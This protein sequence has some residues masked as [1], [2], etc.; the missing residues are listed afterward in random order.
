MCRRAVQV[1]ADANY[2]MIM[3]RWVTG[4]APA[5]EETVS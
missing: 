4:E 3:R 2:D 1:F 5:A